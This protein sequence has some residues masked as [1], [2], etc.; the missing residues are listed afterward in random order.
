MKDSTHEEDLFIMNFLND[1]SRRLYRA[2]AKK[3]SVFGIRAADSLAYSVLWS[4]GY[5]LAK[6]PRGKMGRLAGPG[7]REGRC[8]MWRCDKF[9]ATIYQTWSGASVM[10]RCSLCECASLLIRCWCSGV[11]A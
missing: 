7:G 10:C 8:T 5:F 3:G 1:K 6:W 4:R 9:E 11:W 2:R